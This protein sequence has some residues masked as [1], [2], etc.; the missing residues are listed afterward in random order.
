MSKKAVQ[1]SQ[2]D[3]D[4]LAELQDWGGPA[5]MS[6]FEAVKQQGLEVFQPSP[7]QLA[8]WRN[9]AK[10]AT[11]ELVEEGEISQGMLDRLNAILA[12]QREGQ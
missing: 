9:Y 1:P 6:A 5:E 8:E 2:D 12:R 10:R 3:L 4:L 11:A 7:E